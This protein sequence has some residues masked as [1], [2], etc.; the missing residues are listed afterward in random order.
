MVTVFLY[1]NRFRSWC[2]LQGYLVNFWNFWSTLKSFPQIFATFWQLSTSAYYFL[3][4]LQDNFEKFRNSLD[5][6]FSFLAN[7]WNLWKDL[8]TFSK[9]VP[10]SW[11]SWNIFENYFESFNKFSETC[12]SFANFYF[13]QLFEKFWHFLGNFCNLVAMVN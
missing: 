1:R 11:K 2:T 4:P 6:F 13:S 7:F 9:S 12:G 5:N 10:P 3:C 8:K